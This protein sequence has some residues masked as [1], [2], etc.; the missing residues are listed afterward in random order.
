MTYSETNDFF[1]EKSLDWITSNPLRW[2]GL[3][4]MKLVHTF[5]WDDITLSN[6]LNTGEWDFAKIVKYLWIDKSI[7]NILPDASLS[8]RILFFT[9]EGIHLIYYYILMALIIMG[10][11]IYKKNILKNEIVPIIFLYVLFG[12]VMILLVVGNVRFKYP[13]LIILLPFAANY[14]Y[15]ITERVKKKDIA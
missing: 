15:Q 7:K 14:I 6:L 1:W 4:P 8:K 12:I 2:L 5:I 10:I 11:F 3:M 9:V 13:Y